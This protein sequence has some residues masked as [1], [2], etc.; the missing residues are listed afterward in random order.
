MNT[1][2]TNSFELINAADF[3]EKMKHPG[4]VVLDVRTPDEWHQY[5]YIFDARKVN[6]YDPAFTSEINKFD[7]NHSYLVYCL[8]G[9]R[10]EEACKI[11]ANLGFAK[12]YNLDGG[13][14]KWDGPLSK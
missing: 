3:Q 2:L 5:G 14:E 12:L 7:K 9:I 10:S 6:I 11:M 1:T 13:L 8:K 4:C